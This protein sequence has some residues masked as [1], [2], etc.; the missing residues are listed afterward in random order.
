MTLVETLTTG[1]LS[2]LH[3][4]ERDAAAEAERKENG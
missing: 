1:L 2:H 3:R 4:I